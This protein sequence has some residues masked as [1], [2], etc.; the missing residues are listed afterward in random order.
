MVSQNDPENLYGGAFDLDEEDR[1]PPL[2]PGVG[3]SPTLPTGSAIYDTPS[4]TNYALP[5][6]QAH[7]ISALF[8][9]A[10][11]INHCFISR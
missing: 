5:L 1:L 9:Y 7:H 3:G 11:G 6:N 10:Y 4:E 2:G 8:S